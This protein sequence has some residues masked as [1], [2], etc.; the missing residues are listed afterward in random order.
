MPDQSE[1]IRLRSLEIFQDLRREEVAHL[2]V[3]SRLP[4]AK[5]IAAIVINERAGLL[6][7]VHP[8]V[9]SVDIA[10]QVCHAVRQNFQ[11]LYQTPC[12]VH[13]FSHRH[14]HVS[15]AGGMVGALYH[16]VEW[17]ESTIAKVKHHVAENLAPGRHPR[18]AEQGKT[19]QPRHLRQ[20]YCATSRPVRVNPICSPHHFADQ[21]VSP[22]TRARAVV[23]QDL[24]GKRIWRY[25]AIKGCDTKYLA[26]TPFTLG[27]SIVFQLI[28]S[29]LVIWVE[30]TTL[31]PHLSDRRHLP[32]P[33]FARELQPDS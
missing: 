18:K 22:L 32:Y 12:Y 3:R 19:K 16:A 24:N 15:L 30:A 21:L 17:S 20:G 7:R 27:S 6:V 1:G 13:P 5:K 25:A 8:E 11:R 26:K 28:E 9:G 10:V 4:I 14:A 29:P 33:S 31:C 23:L 2:A